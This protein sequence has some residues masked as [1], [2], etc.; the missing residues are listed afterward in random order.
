[1]RPERGPGG[2]DERGWPEPFQV[3]G[4]LHDHES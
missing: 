3:R 1:M 4:D 2:H